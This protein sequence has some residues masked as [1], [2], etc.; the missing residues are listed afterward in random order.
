M[1]GCTN[2]MEA[3]TH[4]GQIVHLIY[5]FGGYLSFKV[6]FV[7]GGHK[8]STKRS[9]TMRCHIKWSVT[10]TASVEYLVVYIIT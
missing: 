1:N 9:L 10:V 7:F 5:I 3:V 6:G 8:F 4:L 2:S